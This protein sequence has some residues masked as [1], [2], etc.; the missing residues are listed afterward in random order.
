MLLLVGFLDVGR[1]QTKKIHFT[2]HGTETFDRYT[3]YHVDAQNG[4]ISDWAL[5]VWTVHRRLNWS[6]KALRFSTDR[7]SS[8]LFSLFTDYVQRF[9]QLEI[10]LLLL[11]FFPSNSK[12]CK[13]TTKKHTTLNNQNLELNNDCQWINVDS[14][15][16]WINWFFLVFRFVSQS[17]QHK[18]R[19]S[20]EKNGRSVNNSSRQS[21]IQAKTERKRMKIQD[22]LQFAWFSIAQIQTN[23]PPQPT[24]STQ[25]YEEYG[26]RLGKL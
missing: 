3:K 11:L 21:K 15:I 9:T 1:Q 25:K 7:L 26:L 23:P 2:E 18:N 10:Y 16:H 20:R 17:K 19:Y 24:Y 5:L 22:V 4:L 6:E 13:T 8:V 12:R 14:R